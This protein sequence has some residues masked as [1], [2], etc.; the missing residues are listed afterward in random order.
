MII[1]TLTIEMLLLMIP[2]LCLSIPGKRGII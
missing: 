2:M 1:M